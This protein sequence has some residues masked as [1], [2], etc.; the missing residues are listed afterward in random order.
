MF[1]YKNIFS[2]K[3]RY[4]MVCHERNDLRRNMAYRLHNKF[5]S[6]VVD[7]QM[8]A[9]D[10]IAHKYNSFE[11]IHEL[12][13][14]HHTLV[15]EHRKIQSEL[16]DAETKLDEYVRNSLN[17]SS[18]VAGLEAIIDCIPKL[19]QSQL[20]NENSMDNVIIEIVDSESESES[21]NNTNES[22]MHF[23]SITAEKEHEFK[24][25][26]ETK[27]LKIQSLEK[28]KNDLKLELAL[29]VNNS[30]MME[31]RNNSLTREV[32]DNK[33]E[34]KECNE[35]I[36]LL[37]IRDT[38]MME[39]RKHLLL[40]VKSEMLIKEKLNMRIEN[41]ENE[42][43]QINC[44]LE[45]SNILVKD[46]QQKNQILHE[47]EMKDS[48][49]VNDQINNKQMIELEKMLE[50]SKLKVRHLIQEKVSLNSEIAKLETILHQSQK[51]NAKIDDKLQDLQLE[52][53]SMM[54]NLNNVQKTNIE[55][56]IKYEQEIEKN[57]QLLL[58]NKN[59]EKIMNETKEQQMQTNESFINLQKQKYGNNDVQNVSLIEEE[60]NR[61]KIKEQELK[62]VQKEF[63]SLESQFK[64]WKN[65]ALEY[66]KE[67]QLSI[68]Q[69]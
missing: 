48:F 9:E 13:Q 35:K 37:N 45:Q 1:D 6:F 21:D 44:I 60:R 29:T 16:V 4:N 14:S 42:K 51:L 8:T 18:T 3:K 64:Y 2:F 30:N 69:R 28:Q 23:M 12:V 43:L 39:E 52:N 50:D 68:N 59:F 36:N 49:A 66:E 31:N 32:N 61:Y 11:N 55:W 7:P 41:L 46:L 57:N 10:A 67:L 47:N 27:Q 22:L 33:H 5:H 63:Q 65:K 20:M 15:S 38:K 62:C 26:L 24:A 53:K 17:K 25:N 54:D 40:N 56:K 58:I 19:E 34:I